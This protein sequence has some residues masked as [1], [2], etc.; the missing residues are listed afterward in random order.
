MLIYLDI[1]YLEDMVKTGIVDLDELHK[2]LFGKLTEVLEI[3][4]EQVEEHKDKLDLDSEYMFLL[5]RT[6]K[7]AEFL[8]ILPYLKTQSGRQEMLNDLQG[9]LEDREDM[10][11]NGFTEET[12]KA[13]IELVKQADGLTE[14]EIYKKYLRKLLMN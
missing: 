11:H 14:Q 1:Q 2:S 13:L 12:C 4:P 5:L 8:D 3:T 9:M 6:Q 7:S 10:I